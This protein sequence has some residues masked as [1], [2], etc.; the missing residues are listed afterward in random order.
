M[1]QIVLYSRHTDAW[2]IAD[3]GFACEGTSRDPRTSLISR[4]TPGYPAPELVDGEFEIYT[5]KVDIWA[6][7]CIFYETMFKAKAFGN[8]GAVMA[9]FYPTGT[10]R[11]PQFSSYHGIK[12]ALVMPM[13]VRM[14]SKD[15]T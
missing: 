2:K 12:T 15:P 13:I 10:L 9:Y 4:G 7:G 3:L 11:Q 8:D 14:L 6:L 1:V 5:N